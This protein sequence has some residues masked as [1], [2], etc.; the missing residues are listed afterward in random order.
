HP[1]CMDY[2][3]ELTAR[4]RADGGSWQCIDCKACVMCQ[5]SGDA[6]SLLFCDAC[7]KGYHM[8]CH[9]PKLQSMPT[10]KWAC[11]NC[12]TMLSPEEVMASIQAPSTFI[13]SKICS[14]AE[15]EE[16]MV[17]DAVTLITDDIMPEP[18]TEILT[19]EPVPAEDPLCGIIDP[20]R[21]IDDVEVA[22]AANTSTNTSPAKSDVEQSNIVSS[23]ASGEDVKN[24]IP[25]PAPEPVSSRPKSAFNWDK[26][27][28]VEY[29]KSLGFPKE[30]AVFEEQEIDGPSLMLMSRTDLVTSLQFKLGPALKIYA[31]I[32]KLQV[33]TLPSE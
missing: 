20:L 15:D 2:S 11:F 1:S 19:T 8:Q 13:P 24:E 21:M 26:T 23:T 12:L 27:D 3:V 14:P 28:V 31:N 10:G 17:M 18:T 30:A 29:I 5:D 22:I 9:T 25:I 33:Q 4:I 16:Q 6:S 32:A 7:D